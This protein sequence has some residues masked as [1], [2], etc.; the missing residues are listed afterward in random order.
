MRKYGWSTFKDLIFKNPAVDEQVGYL[1]AL[2]KITASLRFRSQLQCL[3]LKKNNL[4]RKLC[5]LTG[6]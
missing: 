4:M 3:F 5:L 1:T 2:M 6:C